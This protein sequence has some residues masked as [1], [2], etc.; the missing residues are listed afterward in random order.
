[1]RKVWIATLAVAILWSPVSVQADAHAR[2]ARAV[3]NTK[4]SSASALAWLVGGLV[5]VVLAS[6]SIG[7][8]QAVTMMA[9]GA[10]VMEALEAR[11]A[12]TPPITVLGAVLG[13]VFIPDLLGQ[14]QH[15]TP[16]QTHEGAGSK[17]PPADLPKRQH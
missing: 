3:E 15:A 11:A 12:L 1:M 8:I 16:V 7:I 5:G 14:N 4:P 10:E 9:E 17:P 2:P 13:A 6:G